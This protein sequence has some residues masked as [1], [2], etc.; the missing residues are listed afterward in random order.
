[1]PA[2]RHLPRNGADADAGG[3][4]VRIAQVA[5]PWLA[6]PPTGYGGLEWVVSL[7]ADGL[8]DRGHEVTLFAT[9]DSKTRA[10]LEFVFEQAPG[11]RFIDSVWHDT[12]QTLYAFGDVSTFDL[13]HVHMTWSSLAA[14]AVCG[15]P[16]VLTLH[17]ELSPE[18]REM[19]GLVS[20]RL[21]F[22]AISERQRATM[23][24][25]RYA[26][27][28]HNGIDIDAYPLREEKEDFVLFLGRS[29]PEKGPVR[30]VQAAAAAGV[31]LKAAVKIASPSE[32]EHW[33]HEVKPRLLPGTEVFGE[34]S[35][36]QKIDLLGRARAVLF[37]I[38]WNEPFGLVMVE[39]M[40]CGTPVIATP[41]G[42][43]PEVVADNE[44]GFVVPVEDYAR[45]A[46]AALERIEDIDPAACRARVEKLFSKEAMVA[47]Y[48]SV[49]HG[50]L[51]GR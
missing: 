18:M 41:R 25:L 1:M 33:E 7:L 35:H 30:A 13:L 8:V 20:D 46:A 14:G 23:P 43:V 3:Y 19:L 21:W 50:I 2:S 6:V 45:T 29:A 38:D 12:M 47:G 4:G 44:T 49:F 51:D 24:E 34:I 17:G 26:G 28:V 11:P 16:V 48:E 5:P 40:A 32:V 9:G 39:A 22:V 36:E 15:R 27:V 31:E 37:P 10:R 42:S